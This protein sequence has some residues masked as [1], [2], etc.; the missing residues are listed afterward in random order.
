MLQFL[1]S[2]TAY[3][4]AKD[5]ETA[6][7]EVLTYGY[8]LL[9]QEWLVRIGMLL[10]ALPFRLFFHVLAS[11]V[12]FDLIRKCA[13]GAHAKYPIVCRIITYT[14]SF[15]PA[16][17]AEVFSVR[18]APIA[19]VALYLFGVVSLL[20]Y[21]PAETNVKKVRDPQ[22]R[23]RLKVEAIAWLSVLFFVAALAQGLLP[24]ISFVIV[25]T[26]ASACCM[27][28]PW[29]YWINGFDPVTREERGAVSAPVKIKKEMKTSEN[30]GYP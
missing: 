19:Y 13:L 23:K 8:Y 30:Q 4:L 28:H 26:A 5:D 6:D 16:I 11:I 7:V 1:A 14:V 17:L 10:V 12:T 3:Y 18:L 9:Y 15:G 24:A 2:K 29:V 27:V 21:A 25:A 22:K 20:L